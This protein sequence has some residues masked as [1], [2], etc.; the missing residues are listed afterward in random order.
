MIFA[1]MA[2]FRLILNPFTLGTFTKDRKSY[3]TLM[4]FFISI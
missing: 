3:K 1:S 2:F 4:I